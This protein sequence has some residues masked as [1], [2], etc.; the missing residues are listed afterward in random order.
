MLIALQRTHI[1]R[2][3][4]RIT[5]ISN[6][7]SLSAEIELTAAAYGRPQLNGTVIKTQEPKNFRYLFAAVYN[8]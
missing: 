5:F 8:F 1:Y 7:L 2:A 4:P 6:K 3:S